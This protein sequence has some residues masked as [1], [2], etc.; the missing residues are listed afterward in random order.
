VREA[1]SDDNVKANEY[2]Y[3][4]VDI[5]DVVTAHLLAWQRALAIGFRKYIISEN[6][7]PA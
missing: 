2:L 7:V 6:A 4:R 3:R 5:E 1:Y